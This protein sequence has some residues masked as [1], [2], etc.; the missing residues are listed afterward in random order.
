MAQNSNPAVHAQRE[1]VALITGASRGLG[2]TVAEFL[3]RQRW[4][5]VLTARHEVPL[6][7]AVKRLQATGASISAVPG[8]VT[9][10]THRRELAAAVRR[11]GRLDLL[12][13]NASELGASPFPALAGYPLDVFRRVLEVNVVAPL[14][15]IH[16]CLPTL[17]A[18]RGL[19]VN[20]TS[21]AAR[22]G[23]PG[24][25]AYGSS[26]AALELVS[27][28]LATEFRDAG[29]GVVSVDP[30]DLRTQMHQDAYPGQ[31]I[32]DRP[33]PEVTVPFWAWLE[34]QEPLRVTGQR[35]EAQGTVW[36]VPA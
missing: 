17:K 9:Q 18:S 33:L 6:L 27:K 10:E 7:E 12:I 13:N 24:W 20:I 23:Y 31:D 29:V 22:G 1:H 36:E 4:T 25:G 19:V 26:K 3:A 34:G 8:D 11:I 30:G 32:S 35:F 5:L 28:T 16:A 14:A 21:D 2:Y 15:L